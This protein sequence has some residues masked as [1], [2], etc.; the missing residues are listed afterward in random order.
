VLSILGH[1]AGNT[2]YEQSLQLAPS[3][4]PDRNRFDIRF[5]RF[6]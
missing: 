5:I 4:P 3:S 6:G 2:A 1:L